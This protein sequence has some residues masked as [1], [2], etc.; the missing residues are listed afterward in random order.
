M[1]FAALITSMMIVLGGFLIGFADTLYDRALSRW[2]RY[3]LR[4]TFHGTLPGTK[5]FWTLSGALQFLNQIPQDSNKDEERFYIVN[6]ETKEE[7]FE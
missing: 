7:Y 2:G 5:R 3:E 6:L 1:L 4:W